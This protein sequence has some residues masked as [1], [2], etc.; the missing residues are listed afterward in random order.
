M[1]KKSRREA[2]HLPANL[3]RPSGAARPVDPLDSLLQRHAARELDDWQAAPEIRQ[4]AGDPGGR[5]LDELVNRLGG[6]TGPLRDSIFW[7]IG[8]VG[9]PE[10]LLR[11]W[12]IVRTPHRSRPARLAA[13]AAIERLHGPPGPAEIPDDLRQRELELSQTELMRTVATVPTAA[14]VED[15][16]VPLLEALMRVESP[17]LAHARLIDD[18]LRRHDRVGAAFLRALGALSPFPDARTEARIAAAGLADR[19]IVPTG[20][21]VLD[22]VNEPSLVAYSAAVP[23][24]PLQLRALL[25]ARRQ[26]GWLRL[27]D[28]TL[29]VSDASG[30]VVALDV[31]EDLAE[32]DVRARYVQQ[33]WLSGAPLRET[34]VDTATG[35]IRRGMDG[36]AA[37]PQ[38]APAAVIR[39]FPLIRRYAFG[40]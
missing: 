14:E 37:R 12:Q 40:D 1:T 28:F 8:V 11:L 32:P 7:A 10:S 6:A 38:G 30:R 17:A 5:L 13:L 33:S 25:G 4:L 23:D 18:A 16:L 24:D 36:T 9:G 2:R 20:A 35:L 3:R 22:L 29:D 31:T 19:G 34:S 26:S 39:Y 21:G 15:A 27:F